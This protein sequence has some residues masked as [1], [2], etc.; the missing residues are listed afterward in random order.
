MFAGNRGS[1]QQENT[2]QI[3][4]RWIE[5]MRDPDYN[6]AEDRVRVIDRMTRGRPE[7]VAGIS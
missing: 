5:S 2:A 4:G 6:I 1:H 3:P 7:N